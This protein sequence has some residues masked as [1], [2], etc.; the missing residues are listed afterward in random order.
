MLWNHVIEKVKV[1]W[2]YFG[3]D[4]ATWEMAD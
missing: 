2:K 1:K 4:E 3:P